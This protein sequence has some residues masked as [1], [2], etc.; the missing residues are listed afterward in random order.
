MFAHLLTEGFSVS[1]E[2]TGSWLSHTPYESL[3]LLDLSVF[4]FFLCFCSVIRRIMRRKKPFGNKGARSRKYNLVAHAE[5]H[6]GDAGGITSMGVLN[7]DTILIHLLKH[8]ECQVSLLQLEE[9]H[10]SSF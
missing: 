7:H 9:A 1:P 10:E 5:H 4:I 8:Q 3:S 2:A 6:S